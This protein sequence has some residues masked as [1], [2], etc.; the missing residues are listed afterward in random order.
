M[1]VDGEALARLLAESG[2]WDGLPETTQAAEHTRVAEGEYPFTGE[3]INEHVMFHADGERLAEFGIERFL[4][5]LA[6]VVSRYG[7][8]LHVERITDF[9]E[10]GEVPYPP[11]PPVIVN[12][13]RVMFID[14]D[15]GDGE[16]ED[17]LWYLATVRPLAC[18]NDLLAAAGATVRFHTINTGTE[19]G[20]ALLIDPRVAEAVRASGKWGDSSVPR[21][22]ID[23]RGRS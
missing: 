22:A 14:R 15:E 3:A 1:D 4:Q 17:S 20:F 5:E 8:S 12:G 7:V 18:V 16:Y 9:A 6:P 21:L 10:F 2:L 19:D 13:R 11:Y 23:T